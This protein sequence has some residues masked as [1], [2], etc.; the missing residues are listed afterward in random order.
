MRIRDERVTWRTTSQEETAEILSLLGPRR[1]KEVIKDQLGD[2]DYILISKDA[3]L[4]I[5][6]KKRE[7]KQQLMATMLQD[8]TTAHDYVMSW[9]EEDQ[10]WALAGVL[11][12][13]GKGYSLNRLTINWEAREL[14]YKNK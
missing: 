4:F 9:P 10:P 8:G 3:Y 5:E 6:R 13:I 11:S 7:Q 14:R 12:C 1:K 2:G